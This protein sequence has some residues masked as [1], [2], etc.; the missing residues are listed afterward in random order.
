MK[1]WNFVVTTY[2]EG[3]K[4]AVRAL[5]D[6]ASLQ[7]SGHYN[8]LLAHADDPMA[9]LDAVERKAA[10]APVL[11]D[12]VSR[13]APALVAFDYENDE[14]FE[15]QAIAAAVPWLSR[16]DGGSF[17]VRVHRRG[18]GLSAT[19]SAQE[20]RLGKALLDKLRDAGASAKI[21][22]D[23]PDFILSIDAIDGRAGLGLWTRDDLRHHRFLRPD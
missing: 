21:S 1:D 10:C 9:L 20:R 6:L 5:R 22:F 14:S 17:H 15:S 2:P 18:G 19:A 13:I 8:V 4:P 16:L 11:I 3:W 23:D 7:P 12:T